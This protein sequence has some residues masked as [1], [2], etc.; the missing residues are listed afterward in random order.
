VNLVTVTDSNPSHHTVGACAARAAGLSSGNVLTKIANLR[1]YPLDLIYPPSLGANCGGYGKC[2]QLTADSDI[3]LKLAAALSRNKDSVLLPGGATAT[4]ITYIPPRTSIHFQTKIDNPATQMA[5]L[6]AAIN[7]GIFIAATVDKRVAVAVTAWDS[8]IA[9]ICFNR[10]MPE[11]SQTSTLASAELLAKAAFGCVATVLPDILDKLGHKKTSFVLGA[12]SVA[13]NYALTQFDNEQMIYETLMEGHSLTVP[14]PA[15]ARASSS[16]TPTQSPSPGP[17]PAPTPSATV[18]PAALTG[19]WTGSYVCSQGK[20]G[21]R[22]VI[23]AEQNGTLSATFNFYAV[24]DNPGVPSGSF[25]MTGTYS[26]AGINLTNGNWINQPTGYEM[27]DLSAGPPIEGG[28]VIAGGV[29]TPG[30]STFTVTR[31]T[32]G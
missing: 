30:C 29:T 21:L 24:P 1:G 20:T 8:L 4:A 14:S 3:W 9:S 7:L 32:A 10:L 19:T 27:V 6:E 18:S 2:L 12:F 25:T 13:M 17:G 5:A 28:T 11:A 31:G 16:P 22:L 26:A 23:Q 15:H